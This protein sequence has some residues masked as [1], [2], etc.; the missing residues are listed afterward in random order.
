MALGFRCLPPLAVASLLIACP[1]DD[2][3]TTTE[4]GSSGSGTTSS[5]GGTT[6]VADSSGG[7]ATSSTTSGGT[8]TG[9][10]PTSSSTTGSDSTTTG[11][12]ESGST[13]GEETTG[14]MM[15]ACTDPAMAVYP[16]TQG[17]LD[18]LFVVDNSGTMG[19]A[20]AHL[21][22][23]MDN[24]IAR[25]DDEGID[26]RIGVTTSDNG[27]PWCSGTT[28]EGGQLVAT[29]CRS[30]LSEFI[31]PGMV[32]VT[33]EACLDVCVHDAIAIQPTTTD[34]D[35]VPAPRPW[36]E[37]IG[38]ATNLPPGVTPT[39]AL[40][41]LLPQGISGCGFEQPL[42][43][44][45]ASLMRFG[46]AGDSAYGFM[47]PNT[48]LLVV[49]VSDEVDCSYNNDWETIFLPDGNRVFWSDPA[50]PFPTS[51]VCWNAGVA[52]TGG[53]GMYAECHVEDYDVDANPGAAPADAVLRPLSTYT[54][55]LAGIDA[56]NGPARVR[57]AVLGGVPSDYPDGGDPVYAD[58]MDAAFQDSFGIGPGCQSADVTALPPVRMREVAEAFADPGERNVYSLCDADLCGTFERIVDDIVN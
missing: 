37:R 45:W 5:T 14:G 51:A 58:S 15:A 20:Q 4:G 44:M 13:T 22:E 21:V 53:P 56:A 2:T 27:N 57:L 33:N 52:C 46:L 24:F 42:R 12:S 54:D 18:V 47:R 19:L 34:L 25:L 3:G 28:P 7:G 9:P 41:C 43:G 11:G 16:G 36:I 39:E 35:P 31:G 40:Q 8:S 29:S 55:L 50:S 23:A 17:A 32:D 6:M 1:G 49:L 30:R 10:E 26:F 48:D 38:G